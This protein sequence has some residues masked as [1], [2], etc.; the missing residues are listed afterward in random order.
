M[1]S[2]SYI[3]IRVTSLLLSIDGLGFTWV[4][5]VAYQS[6]GLWH[7]GIVVITVKLFTCSQLYFVLNYLYLSRIASKIPQLWLL[8]EITNKFLM[9]ICCSDKLGSK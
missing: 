6:H 5:L 7:R 9:G 8:Q 4:D 2:S 1:N 3:F